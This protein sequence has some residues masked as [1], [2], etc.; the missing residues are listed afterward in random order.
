MAESLMR[1]DL[2][3]AD[4]REGKVRD[5]YRGRLRDGREAVVLVASDR[6][7]AFDVVMPNAV[8]GKGRLLTA[9][10][11]W[12]FERI[13]EAT[14]RLG[15]LTHHVLTT[16]AADIDGLDAAQRAAIAGRVT[17]GRVCRV[18]PI[19]CVVRGYLAGSGWKEYRKTGEVC[20][21]RLPAGLVES[22]RLPEPI[23]T[24]ATKAETGHDENISF[25]RAAEIAGGALMVRLADWSIR[26]YRLGAEVAEARGLILA[27][28][29]FEFG[30][31]VGDDGRLIAGAD[32]VLIDEALTMDSSRYWP[33]ESYAPGGPQPS[34]DKQF[35][36]DYL[37]RLCD[38]GRWDKRAPGPEL[39]LEVIE[40]TLGRY[41]EGWERLTG[42][43]W[44]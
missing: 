21:V 43:P 14:D 3:L 17:A 6:V 28:T 27:D 33:A 1:S 9:M 20:G 13:A 22:D 19:E 37:Q 2:P 23:F 35:V 41:R 26:L 30:L 36:R 39:P 10:A 32:P 5:T 25:D 40:G 34:F 4:R 18:V 8:P 7:S 24:P 29:K 38:A 44:A 16:D 12:W 31:P 42:T 11:A 15:G